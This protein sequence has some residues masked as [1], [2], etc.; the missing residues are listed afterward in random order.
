M[1]ERG[2]ERDSSKEMI[3]PKTAEATLRYGYI[4]LMKSNNS[5]FI[6]QLK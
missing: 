6:I 5:D 2:R 1:V 3:V 4:E